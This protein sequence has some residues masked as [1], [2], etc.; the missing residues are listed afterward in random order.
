MLMYARGD[1]IDNTVSSRLFPFQMT[2][3]R[4]YIT[5]QLVRA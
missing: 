5:A 1:A 4:D 2:A 3:V